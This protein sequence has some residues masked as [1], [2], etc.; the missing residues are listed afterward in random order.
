[1]CRLAVE[2]LPRVEV[3]P[4]ERELG[5]E[6]W[7]LRTLEHFAAAHPGWAMRLLVGA[8]VLPDLPKWHRFDRIAELARPIVLGRAGFNGDRG[9]PREHGS[10][11]RH[12]D[13]EPA[14]RHDALRALH[15]LEVAEVS[16][17]QISS[18]EVREALAAGDLDAVRWC[19]PR[20][21]LE[22]IVEHGLYGSGGA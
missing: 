17:P 2:W 19:L 20:S 10:A 21:V 5:G 7:T 8:D 6:S 22:Y 13:V 1:M 9:S 15:A 12:G 18:T 3:S 16:L 14:S 4:V 11:A